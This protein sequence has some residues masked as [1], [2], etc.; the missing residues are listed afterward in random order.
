MNGQQSSPL[1]P[2]VI[3]VLLLGAFALGGMAERY[4]LLPGGVPSDAA[5]SFGPFWEAW[6][7]VRRDYVDRDKVEPKNLT[8]GAIRGLVASLGDFGH[9][10]YLTP[11]EVRDLKAGLKGEFE[12][13]GAVVTVRKKRPTI[14]Q[15]IPNSP[16]EEAGL[17]TGDVFLAVDDKPV[18]E[19]PLERVVERVRGP[20]GTKV[21]LLV[22]REG[23]TKALTFEITRRRVDVP[24]VTW[25]RLQGEPIGHV[26]IRSFSTNTDE[27]LRAALKDLRGRGVKGVILDLRGNPGGLKEQAVAVTS[28]FLKGG[29]VFIEQ[30][31]EGNQ[32]AV[33]VKPGG[34]ATDLPLVLLI[35]EGTASSGEILAGAIQDH[36][37]G[38][39]VGTRTFGTGTVL[40]PFPLSDGSA[41]LLAVRQWLTPQGRKIWH[42]GITPDIEV[43]LPEGATAV[44]PARQGGE[45]DAMTVTNSTDRQFGKALE[46]LKEQ[47]R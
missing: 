2:V 18:L 33:P 31:A 37:R 4:G 13:I 32:K 27:R 12:G 45:L 24:T 17:K 29:N 39:L 47:L 9:T 43:A 20:A 30:D 11:E 22:A 14:M 35:D 15:V 21:K 38:K 23:V 46:V 19:L 25:Q 3:V 28:E 1:K 44:L 36:Q 41:L 8:R 16:A 42:E 34:T 7:H 5:A 26:A 10:S 6:R 40:Q